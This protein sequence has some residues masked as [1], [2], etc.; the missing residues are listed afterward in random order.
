M[1]INRY[2]NGEKA[3]DISRHMVTNREIQ[4]VIREVQKRIRGTEE[5]A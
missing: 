3:E 4:E 5:K 1:Q 2:I